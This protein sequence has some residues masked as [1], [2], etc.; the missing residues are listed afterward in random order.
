MLLYRLI[1]NLDEYRCKG[2]RILTGNQWHVIEMTKTQCDSFEEGSAVDT[3][4]EQDPA[5][6]S[7]TPQVQDCPYRAVIARLSRVVLKDSPMLDLGKQCAADE[8]EVDA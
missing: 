8:G 7:V 4:P 5:V 3:V 2:I 1:N 6:V